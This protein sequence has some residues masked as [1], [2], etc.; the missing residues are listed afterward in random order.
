[1]TYI[2]RAIATDGPGLAH[3]HVQSWRTTYRGIVPDTVLDNLSEARRRTWWQD[4]L[5]QR[6][7]TNVVFVAVNHAGEV[8]G[9]AS[10]GPMREGTAGYDAELYAI[11]L[12]QAAQGKGIGRR[13]TCALA[14]ALGAQGFKSL[15]VWVLAANPA[16]A[17][18]EALG[19]TSVE[20]RQIEIGGESL[21]EI[22]YGWPDLATLLGKCDEETKQ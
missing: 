4:V 1:M 10:G 14:R 3:V 7:E 21:S 9:F 13:L 15:C 16:Y 20:T 11:Y 17:F 2:R 22:A 19:G 18:Y 12:L 6:S 8:V 5:T